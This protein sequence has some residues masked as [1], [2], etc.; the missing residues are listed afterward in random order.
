M[1]ARGD[2]CW[3]TVGGLEW[4]ETPELW[5]L[6]LGIHELVQSVVIHRG[7]LEQI[8]YCSEWPGKTDTISRGSY[9][10]VR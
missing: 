4:V 3:Q 10:E 7:S 2:G 6:Q 1:Q 5:S 8:Q 9:T